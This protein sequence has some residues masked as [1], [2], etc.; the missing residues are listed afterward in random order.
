MS[1][2]QSPPSGS[3]SAH[4]VPAV[5]LHL[6]QESVAPTN[7]IEKR[8]ILSPV[9]PHPVHIQEPS[10]IPVLKNQMDPAFNFTADTQTQSNGTATT[11]QSNP[12]L[13]SLL[14]QLQQRSNQQQEQRPEAS[15]SSFS[16]AIHPI[17]NSSIVAGNGDV[18]S[19][20]GSLTSQTNGAAPTN[21]A[22]SGLPQPPT[23]ASNLPSNVDLQALLTKLSPA[24]SAT[25]SQHPLQPG[26]STQLPSQNQEGA[27][28]LS[29]SSGAPGV[30]T[31]ST[32]Q[33][34][35]PSSS[36]QSPVQKARPA[37]N[38]PPPP[39]NHPLPPVPVVSSSVP[40]HPATGYPASLP[41]PPNFKPQDPGSADGEDDEDI[42]PFTVDEEEEFARFLADERD[43]VTQGQWDRFPPGSRLFIGAHPSIRDPLFPRRMP[44]CFSIPPLNLTSYPSVAESRLF[45]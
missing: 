5:D 22:T 29:T 42:R 30:Q 4:P 31:T 13:D 37:T 38:P 18:P 36:T 14:Q 19:G 9:S 43:Y 41:P 8:Q 24:T 32:V 6:Q 28:V 44:L 27:G 1:E 20:D 7:G 3:N 25:G 39:A 35:P 12:P 23:L 45:A 40:G 10:T 15:M 11:G 17:E 21:I 2:N 34:P 33:G 16:G 26:G